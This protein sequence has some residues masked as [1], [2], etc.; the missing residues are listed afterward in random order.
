MR[1]SWDG[2]VAGID[3]SVDERTERMPVGVGYAIDDNPIPLRV[4]SAPVGGPLA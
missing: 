4:L 2:L 3:D 1:A